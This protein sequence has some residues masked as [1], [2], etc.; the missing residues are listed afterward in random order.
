M[1]TVQFSEITTTLMGHKAWMQTLPCLILT[2]NI[3]SNIK[4]ISTFIEIYNKK[5]IKGMII[6]VDSHTASRTSF[7]FTLLLSLFERW[8][9]KFGQNPELYY[10]Y[11]EVK[12]NPR[13]LL[14]IESLYSIVY[15]VKGPRVFHYF[16]S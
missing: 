6:F 15:I 8:T 12:C 10:G 16:L 2:S 13:S 7:I 1:K 4:R 5:G 9:G 14:I 11:I 3:D